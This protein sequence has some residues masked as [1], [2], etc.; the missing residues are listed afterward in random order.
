MA[1]T[2]SH[3]TALLSSHALFAVLSV[4]RIS[5]LMIQGS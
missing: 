2:Y 4:H 1:V 3:N 5:I